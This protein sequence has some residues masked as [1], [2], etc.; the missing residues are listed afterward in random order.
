[1][2]G[3]SSVARFTAGHFVVLCSPVKGN[4]ATE[5]PLRRA[6]ARVENSM[7]KNR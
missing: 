5:D 1:M 4:W 7:R 6:R 2:V 3:V